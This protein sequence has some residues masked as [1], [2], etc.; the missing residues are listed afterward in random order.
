MTNMPEK[1]QIVVMAA[2]RPGVVNELAQAAGVSHKCLIDL[3]GKKLIIHTLHG[4]LACNRVGDITVVID[5]VSVLDDVAEINELKQSGRLQVIESG[6]TLY[7]SVAL[8]LEKKNSFPAIVTTADNV[9]LTGAM[10]DDF[11]EALDEGKPDAALCMVKKGVMQAKYPM[12]QKRFHRFKDGEWS[13]AN[14]YAILT[15]KALKAAEIFRTGGQFAKRPDRVLKAFGVINAIGYKYAWFRR[16]RAISR[17]GKRHGLKT[18]AIDLT[19]AE[20][21]IDVDNFR[22]QK[23][24]EL[25]LLGQNAEAAKIV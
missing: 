15:K 11:I 13:N 12:G 8:A 18:I 24:A 19:Q 4:I 17:I 9:L 7:D 6:P 5:T 23:I 22:S 1:Y 14:L 10:L 16:D 25:I 3:A 2:Q 21:P 20:A